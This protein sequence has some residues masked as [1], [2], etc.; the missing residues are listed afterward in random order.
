MRQHYE[1][2][3]AFAKVIGWDYGGVE[4]QVNEDAHDFRGSYMGSSYKVVI[5]LPV[6]ASLDAS[7]SHPMMKVF[8]EMKNRLLES[9]AV[10]QELKEHKDRI[11]E[12]E[13]ELKTLKGQ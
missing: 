1:A 9:P 6:R 3:K 8:V 2:I 12:L 11:K 13:A 7:T 10:A 5:I 4:I